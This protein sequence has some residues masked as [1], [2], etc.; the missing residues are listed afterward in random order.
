MVRAYARTTSFEYGHLA[1]WEQQEWLQAHCEAPPRPLPAETR[2]A[3][4]HDLVR[5]G[6]QPF[7][8]YLCVARASKVL[9]SCQLT[10]FTCAGICAAILMQSTVTIRVLHERLLFG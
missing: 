7:I 4:L 1:S 10:K 3:I 9:P 5:A 2:R 6:A 8:V